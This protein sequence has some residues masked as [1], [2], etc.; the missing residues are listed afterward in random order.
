M[1]MPL[2]SII[3]PVYN[4]AG[5]LKNCLDSLIRCTIDGCE[6]ILID[7]GSVDGSGGI[8]D[9]Y[10]SRYDYVSCFHSAHKG[11]AAA[12]NLGLDKATRDYIL[13]VDGDDEWN[14]FFELPALQEIVSKENVDL[15][16]TGYCIRKCQEGESVDT[17][18]RI[19]RKLFVDWRNEKDVFLRFFPYGWMHPCWN[20]VFRRDVIQE[21]GLLFHQQQMEDFRFVLEYLTK[22]QSV[23]FI[24]IVPYL[25]YKRAG[26]N[27]LTSFISPVM[28]E[29]TNYCHEMMLSLFEDI[30]HD[31]IH[32][33]LAPQYIGTI[34][35]CLKANNDIMVEQLLTDFRK[36]KLA[37]V[38]FKKYVTSSISERITMWLMRKGWYEALKRY[39]QATEVIK[40]WVHYL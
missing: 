22:I 8:C 14:S 7:D 19:P 3:V 2:F 24:P 30:Y 40:S 17:I 4:C 10:S 11:V 27:S 16:V 26:S 9:D 29:G 18:V 25:Y 34:N 20:K 13:F 39:R 28:L 15:V 32:R 21:Y 6:I 36:N 5:Y 31:T 37:S 33:I 23:V 35:R 38:S 12:R 1:N